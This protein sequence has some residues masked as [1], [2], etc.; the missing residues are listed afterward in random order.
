MLAN[1]IRI[2]FEL[3]KFE[4]RLKHIPLSL[5]FLE[6]NWRIRSL[7]NQYCTYKI[8]QLIISNDRKIMFAEV[9]SVTMYLHHFLLHRPRSRIFFTFMAGLSKFMA[10]F[11][12][13]RKTVEKV[14]FG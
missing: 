6:W 8:L 12:L 11:W 1:R 10:A 14:F 4:L 5:A 9:A 2:Y 7:I 3:Q 13:S